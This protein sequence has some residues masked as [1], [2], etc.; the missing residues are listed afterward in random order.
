M[1][2][3]DGI[4]ARARHLRRMVGDGV[5]DS[6]KAAVYV[7]QLLRGNRAPPSILSGPRVQGARPSM[8]VPASGAQTSHLS[9]APSP[10]AVMLPPVLLLHGY[11]ATRGSVHLLEERLTAFGHVVMTYRLGPVHLGDIR[12]SAGFIARKVESLVSQTGVEKV[13]VVAHSMGGLVALDYLKRLQGHRR[14]RRLV[15]LGT[16]IL[17]TW[18]ALLGIATAPLGRAALQ[19]LPGS[20]FLRDLGRM[21]IP[22]GPEVIA[23]SGDR[24]WLAPP[25][26]TV[27]EGVRCLALATGHSGLLVD[28]SVAR[29]ISDILA[30]APS[31]KPVDGL[32]DGAG[33]PH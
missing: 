26:T 28:E 17:G 10:H 20:S 21:P 2:V 27:F 14:V 5:V 24:D 19:L 33:D 30:A 32:F 8:A 1:K 25:H 12:D 31:A 15:L 7:R 18:T 22:A 16:P 23:I 29:T 3:I 13:D 11:L 4:L 9:P 6:A